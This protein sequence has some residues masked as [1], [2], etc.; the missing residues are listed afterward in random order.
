MGSS[1]TLYILKRKVVK[2]RSGTFCRGKVRLGMSEAVR[3]KVGRYTF[4]EGRAG[5]MP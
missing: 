2:T 5:A 4:W 3:V 1:A